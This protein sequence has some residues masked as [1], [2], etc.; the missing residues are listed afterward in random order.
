M[1]ARVSLRH[2]LDSSRRLQFTGSADEIAVFRKRVEGMRRDRRL[3]LRNARE[4]EKDLRAMAH[5]GDAPDVVRLWDRYLATLATSSRQRAERAWRAQI[6]ERWGGA[7]FF[8]VREGELA[9]WYADMCREIAPQGA[10]LCCRFLMAALRLAFRDR[11]IDELPYRGWQVPFSEPQTTRESCRSLEELQAIVAAAHAEDAANWARG[12]YSDFAVRVLVVGLCGMRTAEA[13]AL[14]WDDCRLDAEPFTMSIRYQAPRDWQKVSP[15]RPRVPR[16]RGRVHVL[17]MHPQ[18]IEALQAHRDALRRRGVYR[19]DGPVFPDARGY[20][21]TGGS[22]L[23][24]DQFRRFATAAGVANPK[25][26]VTHSLRHSFATLESL[27]AG[28]DLRQLQQRT[29]HR[30]IKALEEYIHARSRVGQMPT[31][32]ASFELPPVVPPS[33]AELP[34]ARL[35]ERGAGLLPRKVQPPKFV[36]IARSWHS[37]SGRRP[38][39]ILAAARKAYNRAYSHALNTT[40]DAA[41]ARRAGGDAKRGVWGAWGKAVAHVRGERER[42]ERGAA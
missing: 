20:W 34:P 24:A 22:V 15:D 32:I 7:K 27:G 26:W 36:A 14:G 12:V 33:D 16:K 41:A 30:T 10:A 42:Q 11:E 38:P 23:Q 29:G 2:P 6:A 40:G 35:L 13:A 3:G 37:E 39:E 28:G 18:V 8:E 31:G 21:R 9:A 5:G 1:S 4:I 17:R 19:D 25:A